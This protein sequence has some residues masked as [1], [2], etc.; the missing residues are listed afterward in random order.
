MLTLKRELFQQYYYNGIRSPI[1]LQKKTNLSLSTVKPYIEKMKS[2]YVIKDKNRS[3]TMYIFWKKNKI[4]N[5]NNQTQA[6][7]VSKKT[8]NKIQLQ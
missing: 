5:N 7:C 1:E 3:Q 6:L 4:F 8:C 2:S